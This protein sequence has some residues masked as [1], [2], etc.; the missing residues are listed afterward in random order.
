MMHVASKR[1]VAFADK[2][3]ARTIVWEDLNGFRKNQTKENKKLHHK[4]RARN[5][6]WPYAVL[7]FFSNYKAMAK[8]IEFGYVPARNTSR[9]CPKCGH[10]S[11]SNRH[12]LAFRCELCGHQDNAD[13]VGATNVGLRMLLQ[14]QATE[15]RAAIN[16]LKVAGS[17]TSYK[18]TRL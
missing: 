14:R 12:G 10:V 9:G 8:G 15:E 11:K 3:G 18:P 4:Q 7:E 6:R 16:R 2:V 17:S 1:L 5:N 13:R